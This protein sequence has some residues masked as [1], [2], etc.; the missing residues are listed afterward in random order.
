M[1]PTGLGNHRPGSQGGLGKHGYGGIDPT[2]SKERTG[3]HPL[4]GVSKFIPIALL[5]KK[6]VMQRGHKRSI[7]LA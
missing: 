2:P 3:N 5:N 1:S 4:H 7:K 6:R